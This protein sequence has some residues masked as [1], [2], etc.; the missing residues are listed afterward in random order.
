[1]DTVHFSETSINLHIT[2]KKRRLLS[3]RIFTESKFSA[4]INGTS[5]GSSNVT[6]RPTSRRNHLGENPSLPT[7]LPLWLKKGLYRHLT[8]RLCYLSPPPG[9]KNTFE[10]TDR[11]TELEMTVTRTAYSSFLFLHFLPTVRLTRGPYEI[12]KTKQT[13]SQCTHMRILLD[14]ETL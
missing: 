9:L 2:S 10:P 7:V 12:Q 5:T 3:F 13:S 14:Y 6:L 11:V 4:Y 8:V 1:M